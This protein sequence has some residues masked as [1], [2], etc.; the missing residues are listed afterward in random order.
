MQSSVLL[1]EPL[2]QI[3]EARPGKMTPILL[4][5][6]VELWNPEAKRER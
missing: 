1:T 3:H 2:H 6:K 4:L 5:P